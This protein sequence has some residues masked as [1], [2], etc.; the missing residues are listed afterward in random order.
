MAQTRYLTGILLLLTLALCTKP[1]VAQDTGTSTNGE[2]PFDPSIRT[3]I[4]EKWL[5]LFHPIQCK[6]GEQ[7]RN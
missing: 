1:A 7:G 5:A 3:G 2:I 6:T 4:L